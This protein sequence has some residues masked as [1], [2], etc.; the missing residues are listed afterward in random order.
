MAALGACRAPPVGKPWKCET[1]SAGLAGSPDPAAIAGA[2]V[3][4]GESVS[5]VVSA[6][7]HSVLSAIA[8]VTWEGPITAVSIASE[9]GSTPWFDVTGSAGAA[10]EP[11]LGLAAA[12]SYSLVAVGRDTNGNV[13]GSSPVA[14]TTGALPGD[15]PTFVTSGAQNAE[16]LTLL[17]PMSSASTGNSYLEIVNGFGFPVWYDLIPGSGALVG[18]FQQQPDGTFTYATNPPPDHQLPMGETAVYHQIDTLGNELRVW[19]ALGPDGSGQISSD[20][21][22][23]PLTVE[24]T[25]LHEFRL[26]PDGD[27]LFF[28]FTPQTMDLTSLGGTS[29]ELVYGTVLERV[30]ADGTVKFAWSSLEH[31]APAGKPALSCV[32]GAEIGQGG[33]G[34]L[35][36]ANG[37]DVMS[38]GNYLVTLRN[39]SQ[40]LKIDSKTGDVLWRLGGSC[41]DFTFEN[42]P[43]GGVSWEHAAR[44]LPNGDILLFDNGVSD[45][46]QIS[47][48]V[49]YSLDMKAR[50]ATLVW[51]TTPRSDLYTQALGYAQRL[52]NGNTLVDFG[53][54]HKVQE[55]DPTG[56][57]VLWTLE[58]PTDLG[59]YRA[60]RLSSLYRYSPENACPAN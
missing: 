24:A 32:T 47:R 43:L 40:V 50:T 34:N 36:H 13:I 55:W 26:Q 58:V 59:G 28:G 48:A 5:L 18:D 39:S 17:A 8:Q 44:E 10:A 22:G 15:L 12:T 27:A 60:H 46:P 33:T 11:V 19:T 20:T 3:I 35:D 49:E 57:S 53:E 7:P 54:T 21:R 30:G 45:S 16:T 29:H 42:D 6:N 9:K 4:A 52:P 51:T 1:V 2:K 38:D 23:K 31:L 14:F 37:I 25:N 56:T 41:S